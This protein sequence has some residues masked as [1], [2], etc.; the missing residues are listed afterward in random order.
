MHRIHIHANGTVSFPDHPRTPFDIL[1]GE[2]EVLAPEPHCGNFAKQVLAVRESYSTFS[3]PRQ[4]STVIG[5]LT[6]FY[7][8]TRRHRREIFCRGNI[9]IR[10]QLFEQLFNRYYL[11]TDL[12]EHYSPSL[13]M[14]GPR[15]G[16]IVML[17]EYSA[18]F[19]VQASHWASLAKQGKTVVV[20]PPDKNGQLQKT[21][22]LGEV[23]SEK[24]FPIFN[25]VREKRYGVQAQYALVQFQRGE[26][27]WVDW[28][29]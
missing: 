19:Q 14:S 18:E 22:T 17:R 10:R 20:C 9:P 7:R 27:H 26:W 21:L 24:Q 15:F 4:M 28:L 29:V 16:D 5:K 12:A 13:V 2:A 23:P 3:S 6:E 8:G 11:K 25:L 1:I